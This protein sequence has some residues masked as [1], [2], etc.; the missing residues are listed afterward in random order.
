[1][2]NLGSERCEGCPY[3]SGSS[4]SR[5]AR[6]SRE[7]VTPDP[8]VGECVIDRVS[9]HPVRPREDLARPRAP[10]PDDAV[11][12]EGEN[13]VCKRGERDECSG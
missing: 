13:G 9:C 3:A 10:G 8:T 2:V 6:N 12:V 11:G 5:W 4:G 7:R 1:M